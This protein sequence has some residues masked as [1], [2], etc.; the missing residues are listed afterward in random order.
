MK[1]FDYNRKA[2]CPTDKDALEIYKR[3]TTYMKETL[4]V[5]KKGVVSQLMMHRNYEDLIDARIKLVRDKYSV[6]PI[7]SLKPIVGID[8]EDKIE[9][10]VI[11]FKQYKSLKENIIRQI[12][13]LSDT[14]HTQ[15]SK[16]QDFLKLTEDIKV[17][18]NLLKLLIKSF[19][20]G[21]YRSDVFESAIYDN[22][23]DE[24]VTC[25]HEMDVCEIVGDNFKNTKSLNEDSDDKLIGSFYK[26]VRKIML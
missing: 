18:I 26:Y 14:N 19:N 7:I 6:I 13:L 9:P 11:F 1:V 5:W 8:F 24:V 16:D 23:T 15:R 3:Y 25:L 4:E 17:N 22:I 10:Y 21:T 12:M 2:P 20:E